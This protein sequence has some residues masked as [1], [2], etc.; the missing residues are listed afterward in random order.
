MTGKYTIFDLVGMTMERVEELCRTGRV[1]G[2][3]SVRVVCLGSDICPLS[4]ELCYGRVGVNVVK[5]KVTRVV[6]SI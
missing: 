2:I 1:D 4:S 3:S 6:G 5:G